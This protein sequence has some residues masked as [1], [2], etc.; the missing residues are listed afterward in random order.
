M[1][2]VQISP[3]FL[4]GT[5]I[6]GMGVRMVGDDYANNHNHLALVLGMFG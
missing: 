6:V 2:K 1:S 5:S 4:S 3:V